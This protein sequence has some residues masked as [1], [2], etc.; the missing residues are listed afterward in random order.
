[1]DKEMRDTVI[2]IDERTLA[3]LDHQEK[4]TEALAAHEERDR[5]DFKSVHSRVS[6]LERKQ[7]WILGIGTAAVLGATAAGAF[8]KGMFG[9]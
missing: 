3:I 4:Q 8:F 7:N 6:R 9:V 2:R 5:Q 1:M